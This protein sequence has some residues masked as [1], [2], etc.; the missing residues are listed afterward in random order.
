MCTSVMM[1]TPSAVTLV[2]VKGYWPGSWHLAAGTGV[3]FYCL[4]PLSVRQPAPIWTPRTSPR[5][6]VHTSAC[7]QP[8]QIRVLSVTSC[9]AAVWDL[10]QRVCP[11][12]NAVHRITQDHVADGNTCQDK[13]CLLPWNAKRDTHVDLRLLL[14]TLAIKWLRGETPF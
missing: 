11:L 5:V 13:A 14:H 6:R 10:T 9:R 1:L 3:K 2:Y 8:T 12:H 4:G 7:T